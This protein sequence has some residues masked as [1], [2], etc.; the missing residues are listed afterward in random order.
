VS[1]YIYIASLQQSLNKYYSKVHFEFNTFGHSTPLLWACQSPLKAWSICAVSSSVESMCSAL[2]TPSVIVFKSNGC[3]RGDRER[4]AD[5][6]SL[7]SQTPIRKCNVFIHLFL[8]F[9]TKDTRYSS[10]VVIK[11]VYN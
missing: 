3:Q 5:A 9:I 6:A 2:T 8:S 7:A 1:T 4:K 11:T 10:A